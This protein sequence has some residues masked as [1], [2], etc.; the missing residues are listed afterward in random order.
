[1]NEMYV[2]IFMPI[3]GRECEQ[4]FDFIFEPNGAFVIEVRRRIYS[5]EIMIS[6]QQ[7][8]RWGYWNSNTKEWYVCHEERFIFKDNKMMDVSQT[9]DICRVLKRGVTKKK[10]VNLIIFDSEYAPTNSIKY[11]KDVIDHMFYKE[12]CEFLVDLKGEGETLT[13]CAECDE[14]CAECDDMN[15]EQIIHEIRIILES[16]SVEDKQ[17]SEIMP[18]KERQILTYD[19][20]F[21][22]FNTNPGEAHKKCDELDKK[23][24][25]REKIGPKGVRL[26]GKKIQ[27][28]T[29]D[30]IYDGKVISKQYSNLYVVE[31]NN[32][33]YQKIMSKDKIEAILA[34]LKA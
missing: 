21:N 28:H 1:M 7:F 9:K 5:K 31:Y 25:E 11:K 32:G 20:K 6:P 26:V 23:I 2:R 29:K 24:K 12:A 33:R 27:I 13:F 22:Q 4:K 15:L 14:F 19:S 10:P 8:W 17:D 30:K 3:K 18:A 16:N 34:V